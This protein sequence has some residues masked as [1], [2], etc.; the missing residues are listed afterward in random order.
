MVMIALSETERWWSEL[1][2]SVFHL[3]TS[4]CPLLLP[5]TCKETHTHT[6]FKP[7]NSTTSSNKSLFSS[8]TMKE[9][10]WVHC[11]YSLLSVSCQGRCEEPPMLG[12]YSILPFS[13]SLRH[14][15]T[16]L[17]T[18]T[19][20][21]HVSSSNHNKDN[22]G[23]AF[24][25]VAQQVEIPASACWHYSRAVVWS[26]RWSKCLWWLAVICFFRAGIYALQLERENRGDKCS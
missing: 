5:P 16:L 9:I 26:E 6:H 25:S 1:A 12:P 3:C 24:K 17:L 19:A 10:S 14:V 8:R 15:I 2:C 22:R 11:V 20:V 4:W 13:W 23:P 21:K 18:F 7:M